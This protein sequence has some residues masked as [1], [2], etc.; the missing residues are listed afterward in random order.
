MAASMWIYV[1]RVLIPYQRADA[2]RN[3]RPRGN[4]SD[5]YPRWLGAR[6]LLLQHRDPY[7]AEITR[8][9]QTGY[10][11]RELDP[12]RAND[13]KDQ[14][15][16]A[17]PIY[18]AFLLAPTIYL[19][20]T[21]VQSAFLW[22]LVLLTAA[23][24]ALWLRAIGW[25]PSRRVFVVLLVLTLGSF[26]AAQGIKLQQLSLLVSFL[27]AASCAALVSGYLALSGVILAMATIK[28]QLVLP[29]AGWLTVWAFADS[30]RRWRFLAGFYF[31]L[32]I[33]IGAGEY[34]LPGWIGRFRQAVAAY[35]EYTGG[36]RSLLDVLLTQSVGRVVA[37]A[38]ILIVIYFC[39]KTRHEPQA[40]SSFAI[41]LA[42]VLAA[43]V[44]IIPTFAPYNQV[45]LLPAIFL[46]ARSWKTLTRKSAIARV[47][48][49]VSA[50]LLLW[51]WITAVGLAAGSFVFPPNAVQQAWAMPLYTSLAI[52]LGV[53]AALAFLVNP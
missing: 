7:S 14:Q 18:V 19:P 36:S 5:L 6:E 28:P 46:I 11:G 20:F 12:H 17:Y 22:L 3:E 50:G 26:A 2:A 52:P 39:W 37:F 1:Q 40:S 48:L 53:L 23:T 16:F 51:P 44:V 42:L 10:Y 15:G 8:A 34:Q 9:I 27:I 32:V 38:V 29:L 33:L 43:T 49:F 45:L 4:L 13:P 21:V 35:G 25:S 41:S 30:G 24:V 47:V 31:T